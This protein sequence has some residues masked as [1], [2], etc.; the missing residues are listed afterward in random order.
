MTEETNACRACGGEVQWH[1][2]SDDFGICSVC[3]K[4]QFPEPGD[5]ITTVVTS[6]GSPYEVAWAFSLVIGAGL[7]LAVVLML[8]G[9]GSTR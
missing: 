4:D 2:Q 6:S 3:G 5:A 7:L 9:W 1:P 8:L